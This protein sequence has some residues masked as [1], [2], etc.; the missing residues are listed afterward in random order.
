MSPPASPMHRWRFCVAFLGLAACAKPSPI[1]R[2][3]PTGRMEESPGASVLAAEASLVGDTIEVQVL[4]RTPYDTHERIQVVTGRRYQWDDVKLP[5]AGWGLGAAGV[6]GLGAG[7]YVGEQTQRVETATV[8]A[9]R[10]PTQGVD[11]RTV[12]PDSRTGS[13]TTFAIAGAAGAVAL[14]QLG[15]MA[16]PTQQRRVSE[17]LDFQS[18]RWVEAG[19]PDQ[20]VALTMG[21]TAVVR[22]STDREGRA[23][24]DLA[25]LPTPATWSWD[26]AVQV[27]PAGEPRVAVDLRASEAAG[28]AAGRVAAQWVRQGRLLDAHA[29]VAKAPRSAT[30]HAPAWSAFCQAATPVAPTLVEPEAARRLLPPQ[31]PVGC[32]ALASTLHALGRDRL[33]QALRARD[34]QT[35]R[36]WLPVCADADQQD[37][38]KRILALEDR[39]EAEEE[40]AYAR[41]RRRQQATWPGRTT[42]ALAVCAS[43]QQEIARRKR[44]IE[45]LGDRGD[46]GGAQRELD[47][48]RAWFESTGE[49]RLSEAMEELAQVHDEMVDHDID[50]DLQGQWGAKVQVGCQ[51]RY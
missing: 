46:I 28:E 2:A 22:T 8:H 1:N 23:R 36:A 39:L 32:G 4:R 26:A 18:R 50:P 33:K 16:L 13:T 7:V 10:E 48:F 21:G 47:R 31:G 17:R 45:R 27:G 37:L 34:P 3:Q 6:A 19:E 5:A 43:T 14:G 12:Q 30:A 9:G 51:E 40:A 29:I 25:G 24:L 35:A 20:A 49:P 41:E 15:A 11:A 44:A 38:E 42:R